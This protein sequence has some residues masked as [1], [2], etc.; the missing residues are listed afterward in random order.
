MSVR[1][2]H[3]SSIGPGK[4]RS[5]LARI[6]WALGAAIWLF[7]TENFWIDPWL[8]IKSRHRLPSLLPEPLGGAWFLALL[9]LGITVTLLVV[10]QILLMKDFGLTKR[11]KALT[12]I[13]VLAAAALSSEWFFA[14]GGRTIVERTLPHRRGHTVRL[15]WQA[16]TTKNV[17]YNVYRGSTPGF[18]PDKLNS[19][20]I[21]GLSYIDST[22]DNG[23]RYYYVA[24]AIG[25]NGQE[26]GDSNEALATVP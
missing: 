16:S 19:I 8:A 12:G 26:S 5:Y 22:V 1:A 9:M 6:I 24:R 7:T 14:T 20:P 13:V 17:G 21:H 3:N 4:A 11:K 15:Q 25:A 2:R 18:H 10:C 23:R